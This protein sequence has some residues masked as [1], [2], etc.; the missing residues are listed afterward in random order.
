MRSS[1]VRRRHR[2]TEAGEVLRAG[3]G[4]LVGFFFASAC[5]VFG[6]PNMWCL[7]W[8]RVA[9]FG[10]PNVGGRS[11]G[12]LVFRA[13]RIEREMLGMP[14]AESLYRFEGRRRKHRTIEA[15]EVVRAGEGDLVGFFFGCACHV[16]GMPN[17][18]CLPWT[19]VEVFGMPNVGGRSCG[20]LVFHA[21]RSNEDC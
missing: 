9:V 14:N 3:E 1:S 18:W 4:D 2:T 13:V 5:R 17:M 8:T 16:F 7:P 10:M 15:S 19:R 21:V 20:G 12:G 6:M 11:C